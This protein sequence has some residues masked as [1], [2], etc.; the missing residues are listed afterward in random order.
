MEIGSLGGTVF[1]QVGLC[2]PLRTM[3]QVKKKNWDLPI[4]LR[5]LLK[6]GFS[7]FKDMLRINKIKVRTTATAVV[8]YRT[9]TGFCT[10]NLL[11]STL[12][13]WWELTRYTTYTVK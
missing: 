3:H 7:S 8:R 4:K 1:F 9:H 13:T 12:G 11:L 10:L 2:T 6:L 5:H